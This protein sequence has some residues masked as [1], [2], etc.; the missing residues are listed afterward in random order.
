MNTVTLLALVSL[1]AGPAA[2]AVPARPAAATARSPAAIL[3]DVVK[4]MGTDAAWK[5]H[6]NVHMKLEMSFAGMGISGA[7]EHFATKD[8]KSLVVTELP[9]VGTIREGSNGKVCWAQDPINGLRELAGAEAE[10]ARIESVWNP[11]LRFAELYKTMDSKTETGAGGAALECL[12]L[13]PHEGSPVTNCYDATTH[14]QVSQKGS[15]PTPQG[16]TPFS[17]TLKD[18]REVGGMK[19]PFSVETQAGPITFTARVTDVKYDVPVSDKMF[20]P[21]SAGGDAAAP[22][23]KPAKSKSKAKKK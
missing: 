13:T 14:L 16:E 23:D 17:S 9:G 6:K 8:D 5:A 18:W 20:E 3:A 4:A 2:T 21:P 11:E 15:R 10:Q 1:W 22:A 12:V 19:M 7:G